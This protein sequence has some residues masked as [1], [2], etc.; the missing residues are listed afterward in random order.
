MVDFNKANKKIF[1][2]TL[3]IS[4]LLIISGIVVGIVGIIDNDSPSSE[5]SNTFGP[6]QLSLERAWLMSSVNEGDYYLL[7]FTP[8]VTNY[9]Y[10]AFNG[11]DR[12]SVEDEQ[13]DY[14]TKYSSTNANYET[15]SRV[16]LEKNTTYTIKVRAD[17]SSLKAY[18][19]D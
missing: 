1:F 12:L 14:I 6:Y 13:G 4:L 15:C 3:V 2:I 18:L 8:T 11:I 16:F 19:Y 7:Q 5:P 17:A 10:I 9:Y